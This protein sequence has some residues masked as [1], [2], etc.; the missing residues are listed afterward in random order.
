[1]SG[2]LGFRCQMSTSASRSSR[3][4]SR[5]A[6]VISYLDAIYRTDEVVMLAACRKPSL[7]IEPR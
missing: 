5:C 6:L 4:T 3:G 7:R 1:M 2:G